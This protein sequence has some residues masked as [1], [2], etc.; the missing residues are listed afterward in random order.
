MKE[1][2]AK[3]ILTKLGISDFQQDVSTLSGGQKK[4]V[5]IASALATPCDFIDFRS[6]L[7]TI[8]TIIW[9]PG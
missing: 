7:P 3:S 8:W 6:N 2:E 5:A 4:R 9:W 1:Y